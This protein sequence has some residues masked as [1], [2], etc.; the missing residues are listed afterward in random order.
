MHGEDSP[1]FGVSGDEDDVGDDGPMRGWVPPDDRL[2]LHPSERSAAAGTT[3]V[4]S[5]PARPAQRGPWVVGGLTVCVVLALVLSGMV[6]ATVTA[7]DGGRPATTSV[8]ITGVPTTEAD[9]SRLTTPRRM[10]TLGTTVVDSTVALVVSTDHGTRI[11]T[12]VVAEAGGIVVALRPTVGGARSVTVV[13]SDGTREAAVLVG[14]DPTTGIVVL[15][16]P[17]DLPAA[18]F[19]TVDPAT[20]SLAVAMSEEAPTR[21]GSPAAR[22]YAGIVLYAGVA[23]GTGQPS[24]LCATVIAAP[25]T[26][27]DLGSPL[28]EPSGDVAGVLDAVNGTGGSRT[29]DFLPAELVRD[30]A[31]QIV[32]HGSVDHG[33]LGVD[34]VDPPDDGASGTGSG[35]L[36]AHVEAGS[37]AA[38]AG[39]EDGD[40]IVA[41]D[42]AQV[43]S[44]AE[45]ETRLYADP[46]GNELPV[47]FVRGDTV[48]NTSAILGNS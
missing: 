25:L 7:N 8:V 34:V 39:L 22:L 12:G 42:G 32:S 17:D 43:R 11:G 4:A 20:G 14:S 31:A 5:D 44:V 23:T 46:P 27:D 3:D 2:W 47:T 28:V 29:A 15:R 21:G 6:V 38:Q 40:R 9:L 1:G 30:V 35:A 10:M 33:V 24:G 13:E 16:V 48:V 19:T 45:L 26:A 18:E 36:V 41:V 37:S